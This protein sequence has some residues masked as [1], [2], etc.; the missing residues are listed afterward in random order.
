MRRTGCPL[1]PSGASPIDLGYKRRRDVL[2]GKD[3]PSSCFITITMPVESFRVQPLL[4]K[5]PAR[6]GRRAVGAKL[7][8]GSPD[9]LGRDAYGIGSH[10]RRAVLFGGAPSAE[11][12]ITADLLSLLCCYREHSTSVRLICSH[13]ERRLMSL[14]PPYASY[15][16]L[17]TALLDLLGRRLPWSLAGCFVDFLR[18][19]QWVSQS[20]RNLTGPGCL[21]L[22]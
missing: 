3:V 2:P 21:V 20:I 1:E 18:R 19:A 6:L 14:R 13:A 4:P 5:P 11:V 10:K 9:G 12:V 15:E 22:D 8:G 7:S 16:W 17:S